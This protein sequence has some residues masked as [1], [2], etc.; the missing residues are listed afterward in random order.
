[1][2]SLDQV[3]HLPLMTLTS[4][5]GKHSSKA[6]YRLWILAHAINQAQGVLMSMHR[7]TLKPVA[8]ATHITLSC[9]ARKWHPS[10]L[11]AIGVLVLIGA[12]PA[13]AA[14]HTYDLKTTAVGS[15]SQ[16]AVISNGV[17]Q[18]TEFWS[19]VDVTTG[20]N[21]VPGFLLAPGDVVSGSIALDHAWTPANLAAPAVHDWFT[22]QLGGFAGTAYPTANQVSIDYYLG[23]TLVASSTPNLGGFG[24]RI[25]AFPESTLPIPVA[26]FDRISFHISVDQ[27]YD[28]V[29][30]WGQPS[31]VSG[32]TGQLMLFSFAPVPEP[33]I[34]AQLLAGLMALSSLARRRLPA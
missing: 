7:T 29:A 10:A 24:N 26:S 33:A 6:L 27:V 12:T 13:W 20:A 9:T 8:T 21:T 18:Y 28:N 5:T 30:G 31:A 3:K 4:K 25:T 17:Q 22:F 11:A 32:D 1:M 14:E 15:W 34:W 16:T 19:L 23:N 2:N